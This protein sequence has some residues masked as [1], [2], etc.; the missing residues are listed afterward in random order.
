MLGRMFGI[1][2][3]QD[4]I[5]LRRDAVRLGLDDNWLLR[6]RKAGALIRIRQ[7]AYAAPESGS[8]RRRPSSTSR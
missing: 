7:G 2:F 6:M 5:L 4:G 1:P 8:G 3:D